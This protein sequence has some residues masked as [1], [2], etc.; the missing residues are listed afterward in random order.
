MKIL[1]RRRGRPGS[2]FRHGM[3]LCSR[4][5]GHGISAEKNELRF[6]SLKLTGLHL[7]KS[8]ANPIGNSSFKHWSSGAM[9]AFLGHFWSLILSVR[10]TFRFHSLL[11]T[12]LKPVKNAY[13]LILGNPGWNSRIFIA[14]SVLLRENDDLQTLIFSKIAPRKK[15]SYFPLYWLLSRDPYNGLLWSP[16]NWV[17]CQIPYK[18]SKTSFFQYPIGF[19]LVFFQIRSPIIRPRM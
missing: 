16:Q 17:A 6:F 5:I 12:M 13:C 3:L 8:M 4:G 10:K 7:P 19:F 18:H 14:S 2:I 1:L 15:A 11:R 9:F